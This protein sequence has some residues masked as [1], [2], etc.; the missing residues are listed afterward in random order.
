M[1]TVLYTVAAH[2]TWDKYTAQMWGCTTDL[3]DFNLDFVGGTAAAHAAILAL[4]HTET[5]CLRLNTTDLR[6][7]DEI[8]VLRYDVPAGVDTLHIQYIRWRAGR[9]AVCA[10]TVQRPE[11]PYG[12]NLLK[13]CAYFT[14]WNRPVPPVSS[15]E[16]TPT[17][18]PLPVAI[19]TV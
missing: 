16:R 2:R 10:S 11:Y 4:A 17:G 8:C 19:S 5:V 1:T 9:L 7:M 14:V 13:D 15:L 6:D 18:D 12:I 3:T